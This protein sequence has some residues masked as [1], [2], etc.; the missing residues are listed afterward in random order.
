MNNRA[1]VP[2]INALPAA[3][4]VH[5]SRRTTRC[6]RNASQSHEPRQ[7]HRR[8]ASPTSAQHDRPN[9]NC[10][11][12][13]PRTPRPAAARQICYGRAKPEVGAPNLFRGRQIRTGRA[14]PA[15]GAPN[16][17]EARQI[18]SGGVKSIPGAAN[19]FR[20]RQIWRRQ[21][22]CER[23][24]T[25]AQGSSG[26]GSGLLRSDRRTA[27]GA[28][29]APHVPTGYAHAGHSPRMRRSRRFTIPGTKN[30]TPRIAA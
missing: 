7:D 11:I 23:A 26:M 4:C 14:V 5:L 18:H 16:L 24:I 28:D 29:F 20:G 30:T 3:R 1:R 2:H 27:F 12:T 15:R 22:L 10:E 6:D 8:L 13:R 21:T 19:L 17:G 9:T 25:A